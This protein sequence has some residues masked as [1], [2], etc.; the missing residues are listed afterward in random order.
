[1]SKLY[2]TCETRGRTPASIISRICQ[3]AKFEAPNSP[4]FPSSISFC[5]ARSESA[6]GREWSGLWK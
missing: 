4:A 6:S 2:K 1:M 5:I 3:E